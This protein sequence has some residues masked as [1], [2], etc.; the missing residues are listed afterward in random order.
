MHESFSYVIM[1]SWLMERPVLVHQ[2]CEVTK[3]F[4][5][6]SNGGLYFHNYFEYEGCVNYFL[7]HP[8]AANQMGKQGRKYVL[9]HFTWNKVIKNYMNLFEQVIDKYT[10][11]EVN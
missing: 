4:A 8:D 9:E 3:F 7:K 5:S 1:E 2:N 10:N 6:D 11:K